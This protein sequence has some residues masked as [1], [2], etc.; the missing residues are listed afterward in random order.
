M[1]D[2][3]KFYIDGKW[4]TPVETALMDKIDPATDGKVGRVALGSLADVELAVA[5]AA[6]AFETFQYSSREDRIALFDRIISAFEA[7]RDEIG[8]AIT[9]DIGVPTWLATGYQ[10]AMAMDHFVEAR[11]LL[12]DY[13]FQYPMG[14]SVIRR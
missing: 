11:R 3:D 1:R 2:F 7:R 13:P 12:E 10:T 4:V 6:K 14:D 5:A 9:N 8:A